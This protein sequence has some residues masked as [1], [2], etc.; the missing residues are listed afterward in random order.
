VTE[1]VD[2]ARERG[3]RRLTLNVLETNHG[4]RRLY[5]RCGFV[6][7]GIQSQQFRLGGRYLDDLLMVLD[8]IRHT[9]G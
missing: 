4:A 1:A 8:L 5:E 7:E 3:A 6:I 2:R 9:D